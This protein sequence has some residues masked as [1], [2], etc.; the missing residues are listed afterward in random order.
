MASFRSETYQNEYL[1]LGA[2]EVNAVITVTASDAGGAPGPAPAAVEIIIIDVSGSMGHEKLDAAK[3]ATAAAIDCIR[4]G[5]HFGVIA[6][7]DKAS[8]VF[9]GSA[10]LVP[11]SGATRADAKAAVAK[12]EAGGGT[13]IGSWLRE[14]AGLFGAEQGAIKHAILLTD[15]RNETEKP[16]QLDAAL[17]ACEGAFQCDCRG[18]GTDWEVSELRKIASRLLGTVDI[19]AKPEDL[20]TDFRSMMQAAMG[21]QLS[22]VVLRLWVPKNAS[23]SF[24]KQ[25]APTIEDLTRR[26]VALGELVGEYPT[27]A[28]AGDESRD[29]HICISVPARGV[30][31]EMLAGRVSLVVDGEVLSEAK[32]RAVWTD[33]KALST[34]I[35]RQVAHYTGQAEL[36]DAIQEGLE[37]R[38]AG[39]YE[40][41]TQRLGRAVQLAAEGGNDATMK[42]LT[43]VVDVDDAATG[44][45]RLRRRIDEADEMRLDA[46]STKTERVRKQAP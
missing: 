43:A 1:A 13:A 24:V 27:G 42:L 10:P 35:N 2:G 40:T 31:E 11:A 37:A 33:D 14:A 20:A 26:R 39:D 17:A 12:L 3:K 41:A 15:G 46:R 21:K 5:A 4:D 45:V 38:K 6:G 22:D 7:T 29:Y 44:T 16:S 23:V 34:R 36:A 28:W 32:I 19:V 30:G 18:V 9:P 8:Q 25:V